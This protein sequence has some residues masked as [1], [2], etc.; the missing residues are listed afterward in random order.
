MTP[1]LPLR[2]VWPMLATPFHADLSLDCASLARQCDQV[3]AAGAVGVAVLGLAG[4]PEQL[5]QEE[6]RIVAAEV[7]R[8]ARRVSPSSSASAEGPR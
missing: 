7:V 3:L 6:R 4:E 1:V 8:A 2:G 5:T